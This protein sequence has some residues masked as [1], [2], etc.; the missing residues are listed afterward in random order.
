[1]GR[2]NGG[3]VYFPVLGVLE[4]RLTAEIARLTGL[5]KRMLMRMTKQT[6]GMESDGRN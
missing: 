4:N 6:D 2:D 5:V 1:M 3:R